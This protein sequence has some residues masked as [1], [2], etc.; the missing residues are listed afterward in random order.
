MLK[1]SEIILELKKQGATRVINHR[2]TGLY[3]F[4]AYFPNG[5]K[6]KPKIEGLELVDWVDY[7]V[8]IAQSPVCARLNY[9]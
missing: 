6:T 8:N 7:G 9:A 1:P 3:S 2:S 4:T 5:W